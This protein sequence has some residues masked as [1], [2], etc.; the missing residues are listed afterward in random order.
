MS[1]HRTYKAW[2]ICGSLKATASSGPSGPLPLYSSIGDRL[3]F[4]TTQ[5]AARE[6]CRDRGM[7]V[8][9]ALG[10]HFVRVVVSASHEAA[11]RAVGVPES[12]ITAA[13]EGE[14]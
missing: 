1:I 14:R 8:P 5:K 6:W 13:M 4:F 3:P 11:L 12:E 7:T 9:G 2:I 10:V